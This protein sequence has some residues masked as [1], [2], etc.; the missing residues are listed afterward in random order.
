MVRKLTLKQLKTAVAKE[1]ARATTTSER[2]E[3]QR[4]L[5]M[6]RE[7]TST[8]LLRR[9]GKGFRVIAAKGARATG[10]GI[11]QARKFAESTGAGRGLDTNFSNRV[12]K[13]KPKRRLG[14]QGGDF[15]GNIGGLDF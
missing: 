1:R 11:V 5:K 15:F 3:L 4:E 10:R 6:L 8:K 13:R 7:G 14:N 2:A 9:F 12:V